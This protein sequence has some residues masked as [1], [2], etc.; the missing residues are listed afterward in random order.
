M[1]TYRAFIF[2]RNNT[3]A[4]NRVVLFF[5][6]GANTATEEDFFPN[7]PYRLESTVLDVELPFVRHLRGFRRLIRPDC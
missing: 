7:Y 3:F 5:W 1:G 4:A 2:Q 6:P